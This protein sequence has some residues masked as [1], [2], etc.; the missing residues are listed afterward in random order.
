MDGLEESI[1][2]KAKQALALMIK[3]GASGYDA[4]FISA[5]RKVEV[6]TEFLDSE[7]LGHAAKAKLKEI[8]DKSNELL[9]EAPKHG[10]K[11]ALNKV[12]TSVLCLAAKAAGE[13]LEKLLDNGFCDSFSVTEEEA[14][15]L[16]RFFYEL[17]NT[18]GIAPSLQTIEDLKYHVKAIKSL[19]G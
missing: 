3:C 7:N 1:V 18:S 13:A 9:F 8:R 12:D 5:H 6:Y 14:A 19:R 10:I 16:A 11:S 15:V 4:S 17:S 2:L